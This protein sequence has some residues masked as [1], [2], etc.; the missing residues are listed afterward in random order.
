MIVL[1]TM[2]MIIS[3][4]HRKSSHDHSKD[5][6]ATESISY[7]SESNEWYKDTL[8][9]KFDGVHIDTLIAKPIV[10]N[11]DQDYPEEGYSGSYNWNWRVYT[12]CGTVNELVLKRKTIGISFVK[13]GDLDGDGTDEWGYVTQW[14]TSNWMSYNTFTYCDGYWSRFIPSFPIYLPHIDAE[15][16]NN[17]PE[18]LVSKS[19]SKGFVHLKFSDVRNDGEDFLLIDTIVAIPSKE[20]TKIIE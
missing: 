10:M 4:N 15:F 17:K 7:N 16:G 14:P 20:P 18:D 9:G 12:T 5:D 1:S 3:C 2:F 6:M 13:E 19:E 11:E 8:I